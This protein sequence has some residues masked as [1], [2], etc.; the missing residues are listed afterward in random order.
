M[1][2]RST[3]EEGVRRKLQ[4]GSS[5][6]IF[7]TS[8]A[9]DIWADKTNKSVYSKREHCCKV[10]RTKSEN[11]SRCYLK[12]SQDLGGPSPCP[13]QNDYSFRKSARFSI[14]FSSSSVYILT[15]LAIFHLIKCTQGKYQKEL[16][17]ISF[18]VS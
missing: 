1:I 4:S 7:Q 14:N 16:I 13:T 15:L 6:V 12:W 11:A 2:E 18:Y 8:W 5:F 3:V 10:S 17:R 9:A